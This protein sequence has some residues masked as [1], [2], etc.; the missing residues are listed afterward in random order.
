MDI[1]RFQVPLK[2]HCQQ[3]NIMT[4]APIWKRATVHDSTDGMMVA[5]LSLMMALERNHDAI[6]I[7]QQGQVLAAEQ[8]S[9]HR[10]PSNNV[11]CHE[12]LLVATIP[13]RSDPTPMAVHSTHQTAFYDGQRR[14][15][16]PSPWWR[17]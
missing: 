7:A 1:P 14:A 4:V 9:L 2:H 3:V 5:A 12:M 17:G 11:S 15:L 13:S 10:C 8:A 6:P 16:Q